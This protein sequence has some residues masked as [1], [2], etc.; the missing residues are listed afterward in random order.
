M[1]TEAMRTASDRVIGICDTPTELFEEVAHALGLP[2]DRCY[3]D[4]FGLN[5]LGWLREVYSDGAPQLHRLWSDPARLQSVYKVPLFDPAAL[6]DLRLLPTEY[7]YYYEQPQRAFENVRRAGQSRGEA[8]AALTRALFDQLARAGCRHGR[9]V[10]KAYLR[11]RSAG[12]MQ[13]ESGSARADRA[14]TSVGAERLRQDCARRGPRH[15]LQRATPSSRSASR[16]AAT[17]SG[18]SMTTSSKCRAS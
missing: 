16:T 6:R 9:Q 8:I 18:C 3:F 4:Y 7:V 12:Y 15:P 10:Y 14:R 5:H 2:S 11:A 17:S 13:I 1:V